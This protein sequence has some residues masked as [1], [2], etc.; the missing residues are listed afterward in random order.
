MRF[1]CILLMILSNVRGDSKSFLGKKTK[2]RELRK[3]RQP[4]KKKEKRS[5]TRSV[6]LISMIFEKKNVTE[7]KIEIKNVA[8]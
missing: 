3:K 5:G 6:C 7:K 1:M 2:T 8:K 4:K